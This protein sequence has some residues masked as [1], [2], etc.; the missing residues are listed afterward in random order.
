MQYWNIP[1]RA[2]CQSAP[3]G[4][5]FRVTQVTGS[6]F[7]NLEPQCPYLQVWPDVVPA[8]AWIDSSTL[9]AKSDAAANRPPTS[10]SLLS[11][12][13]GNCWELSLLIL[14][15]VFMSAKIAQKCLSSKFSFHFLSYFLIICYLCR[16]FGEKSGLM[17]AFAIISRWTKMPRKQFGNKN[18]LK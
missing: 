3:S 1:L 2:K 14:Y 7:T 13:G 17:K 6:C 4:V 16:W 11:P 10:F 9:R 8:S 5:G 12:C 18:A 15:I